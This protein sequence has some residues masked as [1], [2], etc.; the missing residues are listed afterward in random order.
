MAFRKRRQCGGASG[1]GHTHTLQQTEENWVTWLVVCL[2]CF[3]KRFPPFFFPLVDSTALA[4]VCLPACLPSAYVRAWRPVK[5]LHNQREQDYKAKQSKERER[6]WRESPEQNCH[7]SLSLFTHRKPAHTVYSSYEI[8]ASSAQ[9]DQWAKEI[10][11]KEHKLKQQVDD[12]ERKTLSL[13]SLLSDLKTTTTTRRRRRK[14]DGGSTRKHHQSHTICFPLIQ[15]A[16][17]SSCFF[18]ARRKGTHKKQ[19]TKFTWKFELNWILGKH[20]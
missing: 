4:T 8:L 9:F 11:M 14:T 6:H 13:T 3:A 1:N 15:I 19:T 2:A 17:N 12:Q 10:S 18:L 20:H 16:S 7:V 5:Y